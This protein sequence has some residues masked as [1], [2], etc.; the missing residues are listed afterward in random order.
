MQEKVSMSDQKQSNNTL[1]VSASPHIRDMESIPTIMWAVVLSLIPAGIAGVFTFGFYC[2]YVV[3][4]SCITAVV[5]EAFILR[6]RKLPVL[7]A[8]KDGSAV[9][10]GILLAYTLQIGRAHV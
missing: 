2:L 3:I 6:L 9:V 7:S 8:L 4:F 1:I 5:T 10:T